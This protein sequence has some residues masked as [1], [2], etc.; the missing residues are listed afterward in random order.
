MT[1]AHHHHPPC[2]PHPHPHPPLTGDAEMQGTVLVSSH[3]D[4]TDSYRVGVKQGL[5]R[6]RFSRSQFEVCQERFVGL[7]DI[8]QSRILS[9]RG[10]FNRFTRR[11]TGVHKMQLLG[12][13]KKSDT[14]RCKCFKNYLKCNLFISLK[15]LTFFFLFV[16]IPVI[17]F[18]Y[19]LAVTVSLSVHVFS[20]DC[21]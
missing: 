8:D 6:G 20:C 17:L 18:Y 2:T 16:I 14:N 5:L 3:R 7:W 21:N 19:L 15:R 10:R 13:Q 11:G 1:I 9:I 12:Q 4:K